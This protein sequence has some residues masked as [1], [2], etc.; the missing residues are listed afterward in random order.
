MSLYL[1]ILVFMHRSV[2]SDS[3]MFEVRLV[4]EAGAPPAPRY[5]AV[6]VPILDDDSYYG[7]LIG[8]IDEKKR[9]RTEVF[10][11]SKDRGWILIPICST[12]KFPPRIKFAFGIFVNILYVW[13]GSGPD[14]IYNDLYSMNLHHHST[15][16]I[17]AEPQSI[18][19]PPPTSD[20]GFAWHGK[21]LYI[22]G[23]RTQDGITNEMYRLDFTTKEWEQFDVSDST[24]TPRCGAQMTYYEGYLF[25]FGGQIGP[26]CDPDP[27]N[28]IYRAKVPDNEPANGT[29]LI[30]EAIPMRSMYDETD[31]A[32]SRF[33]AGFAWLGNVVM[34]VGGRFV[35]KDGNLQP[36]LSGVILYLTEAVSDTEGNIVTFEQGYVSSNTVTTDLLY[37]AGIVLRE[38]NPD[39]PDN[40]N[41]PTIPVIYVF[42]GIS[43]DKVNGRLFQLGI[44]ETTGI[45]LSTIT[46]VIEKAPSP[47]A[48]QASC[49]SLGRMWIFGGIGPS[50]NSLV[51]ITAS[52][53]AVYFNDLYS[54]DLVNEE[55]TAIEPTG[56]Q[57][58]EARAYTCLCEDGGLL[59]LFGGIGMDSITGESSVMNDIWRYS[60]S[61]NAW[62]ELTPT[63]GSVAENTLPPARYKAGSVMIHHNLFV[64]G[65][66]SS[67]AS[68]LNDLWKF[69]GITLKWTKCKL[70]YY[71][72]STQDTTDSVLDPRIQP[73][74]FTRTTQLDGVKREV[75]IIAGGLTAAGD[76]IDKPQVLVLPKDDSY[77]QDEFTVEYLGG[78]QSPTLKPR[79]HAIFEDSCVV[80]Y[81]H[82]IMSL[83]GLH[84]DLVVGDRNVIDFSNVKAPVVSSHTQD[85]SHRFAPFGGS[86]IYYGR[87]V[88]YFGGKTSYAK[89]PSHHAFTSD[90]Y[91][92][93]V[94]S[95][96]S[97]SPG[98]YNSSGVC[99]PAE[100]GK[101]APSY[102]MTEPR[103]CQP[104]FVN[105]HYGAS[106]ADHCVLCNAG[107]YTS[108]EGTSE[109]QPCEQNDYCPPGSTIHSLTQPYALPSSNIEHQPEL[110]RNYDKL[111]LV[112]TVICYV[113][114]I[115]VGALVALIAFRLPTRK[116]LRRMDFFSSEKYVELDEEHQKKKIPVS[117][118]K[119]LFGGF[120]MCVCIP[121]IFGAIVNVIIDWILNNINE[122]KSLLLHVTDQSYDISHLNVPSLQ[123]S[124]ELIGY[125]GLCTAGSNPYN[126]SLSS[127]HASL[128]VKVSGIL[129]RSMFILYCHVLFFIII[130]SF[131]RER[132]FDSTVSIH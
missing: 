30:W 118:A 8:G 41:Q 68:P 105:P 35:D 92:F 53:D 9:Y 116:Y 123:A 37:P 58:P 24:P 103:R 124:L 114:P 117:S 42:G 120:L 96:Y 59:I 25:L 21:Y 51:S 102:N 64:F 31:V 16:S 22:F 36:T 100:P 127:C 71:Q 2:L 7:V 39:Y 47:R 112:I 34:F 73:T 121:L 130:S 77:N 125:N 12:Q 4:P 94:T 82:G 75:L 85:I 69:S 81:E 79:D 18:F 52:L 65:G 107:S 26:D 89:I 55:W 19:K 67:R 101:Y 70:R 17:Y 61:S 15:F 13:G 29:S 46:D 88:Y 43:N 93:P 98:T 126:P 66:A 129:D 91:K 108:L 86:C 57:R 113:I 109:C 63:N 122:T 3:N 87:H 27:K 119:T 50:D 10:R 83:Y 111:S 104:G 115:V 40:Q 110:R 132:H 32:I 72:S 62:K 5:G 131:Y 6:F 23:G 97:C 60:I 76:P 90:L 80:P 14:G 28:I 44:G 74:L 11:Y 99:K 95:E 48:Y 1:F 20:P 38:P 33:D 56:E 45:E 106:N 128:H 78:V 84:S 49:Y 54:F